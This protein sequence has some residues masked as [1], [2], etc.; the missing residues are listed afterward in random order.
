MTVKLN[1]S[2]FVK[3]FFN[4]KNR[5]MKIRKAQLPDL[6]PLSI[7]FDDYR[8]FYKKPS[9]IESGKSFLKERIENDESVIYIAFDEK[10]NAL[11][12]VQLYP[13][14]SST[15][16]KRLWLLNDLFV[17]S[18]HRGQGVSIALIERAKEHCIQT[19]SCGMYLETA[20]DNVIGNALYPRTGF[21]L[22]KDH[23]YYS[24]SVQ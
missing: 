8:V 22:D 11:G 10:N 23:N 14:F 12:F 4:K 19:A 20:H 15:R 2:N 5:K 17:A 7:L 13:L 21:E 16:M 1:Q 9:D 18:K 24:W 6:E 3:V